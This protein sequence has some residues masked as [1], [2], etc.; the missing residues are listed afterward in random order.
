MKKLLMLVI[1]SLLFTGF[2]SKEE[3]RLDIPLML[4][5]MLQQNL[6]PKILS[7]T[8]LSLEIVIKEGDRATFSITFEKAEAGAKVSVTREGGSLRENCI[9]SSNESSVNVTIINTRMEDAGR[10]V[11]TL[12]NKYGSTSILF[13]VYVAPDFTISE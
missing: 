7:A 2:T 11:I 3:K 12:T 8:P 13:S 1:I 4:T 5:D 6:P 10:Y 9:Y